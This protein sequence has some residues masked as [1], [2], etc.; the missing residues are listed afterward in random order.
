M[1]GDIN[2]PNCISSRCRALFKAGLNEHEFKITNIK[3]DAACVMLEAN[4]LQ[5]VQKACE[6]QM[7]APDVVLNM[8]DHSLWTLNEKSRNIAWV[9]WGK[10][11]KVSEELANK[12]NHMQKIVVTSEE[13][14]RALDMSG[15][16]TEIVIIDEPIDSTVFGKING[17]IDI[18]NVT[19]EENGLPI[20]QK[21]KS[22]LLQGRVGDERSIIECLEVLC[23]KYKEE[24]LTVVLRVYKNTMGMQ[25]DLEVAGIVNQ[26]RQRTK[27]SGG[28]K[29][30]IMTKL[31]ADEELC[32]LY[33][34]VDVVINTSRLTSLEQIT[35]QP[36]LSNC[37]VITFNDSLSSRY[38]KGLHYVQS[39]QIPFYDGIQCSDLWLRS[40]NQRSLKQCID[41]ALEGSK[42]TIET[43]EAVQKNCDPSL[44]LSDILC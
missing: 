44:V 42:M 15:V 14:M 28:P 11:G 3:P 43:A 2:S 33:N 35:L 38:K 17:T 26:V 30:S 29:V 1:A 13:D 20:K 40:P 12:C 36:I 19:V 34:S 16:N 22:V 24:D 39:T 10:Q 32:M 5:E 7:E 4:F 6:T 41:Q 27:S 9:T 23:S 21:K 25:D 37:S 8:K 31:L 18:A